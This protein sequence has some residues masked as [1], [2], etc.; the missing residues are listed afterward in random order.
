MTYRHR[1][2]PADTRATYLKAIRRSLDGVVA[3]EIHGR[4]GGADRGRADHDSLPPT[5]ASLGKKSG[6]P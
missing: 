5:I 1:G 6:T 3:A 4:T 2:R